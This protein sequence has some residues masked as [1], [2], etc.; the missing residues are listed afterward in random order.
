MCFNT[1]IF[2]CPRQLS[3]FSRICNKGFLLLESRFYWKI[4][5]VK[6][7]CLGLRIRNRLNPWIEVGATSY[8][9]VLEP[10]MIRL[11]IVP[12]TNK[13]RCPQW[14]KIDWI[15]FLILL[16]SLQLYSLYRT[17]H[18]LRYSLLWYTHCLHG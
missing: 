16:C 15:M 13:I 14:Q 12:R 6:T 8:D 1:S 2:W 9:S 4:T 3:F 18:I 10:S 17:L 5:V 7:C 11:N